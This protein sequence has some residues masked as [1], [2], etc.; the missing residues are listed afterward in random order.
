MPG[1]QSRLAGRQQARLGARAPRD[2]PDV[3]GRR[4]HALPVRVP[5]SARDAKEKAARMHD[6]FVTTGLTGPDTIL[7]GLRIG[8][9]VV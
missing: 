1:T 9:N 8:D 2:A 4:R 6:D 3:P 5:A 7:N